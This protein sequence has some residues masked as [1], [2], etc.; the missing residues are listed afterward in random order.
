[1]G[2]PT[3]PPLF[4]PDHP[5]PVYTNP[6]V[7]Q[8]KASLEERSARWAGG[9]SRLTWEI[10][11]LRERSVLVFNTHAPL[12]TCVCVGGHHTQPA[13]LLLMPFPSQ[14]CQK[15]GRF[16]P[17]SE[18]LQVCSRPHSP[19]TC[20]SS[21]SEVESEPNPASRR[22]H[23]E[24]L[25]AHPEPSGQGDMPDIKLRRVLG[26]SSRHQDRVSGQDPS[27]LTLPQ[28]SLQLHCELESLTQGQFRGP[29][30]FPGST[31]S[32]ILHSPS[33]STAFQP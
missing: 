20:P 13:H 3:S 18:I 26:S 10:V 24:G 19:R 21:S 12:P 4:S 30:E 5:C 1:M 22:P 15:S 7:A 8:H 11:H 32:H 9:K 2:T 14:Q 23:L 16:S 17:G 33:T 27:H 29:R 31:P 25:Q 6:L 28:S